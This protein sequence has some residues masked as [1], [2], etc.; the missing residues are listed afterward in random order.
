MAL[1]NFLEHCPV[2]HMVFVSSGAVYDGLVGDVTP[3]RPR[4]TRG[5]PTRSRSSHRSSTSRFFAERRHAVDS[6]ANVRFFGAYG[7]YEP[8]R[9]ITTRWMRAVMAGQRTFTVRGNG[10]NLIDFMYVD[11]AVDA[12]LRAGDRRRTSAA[13]STS[14]PQRR[15]ASTTSSQTMARVLGVEIEVRHE[16]DVPE[17]IEFPSPTPR[18]ANGSASTKVSFEDGIRRLHEF[19]RHQTA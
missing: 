3:V 18:C 14:R 17:Y 2:G 8:E 13:P 6:Y 9:K 19:F 11:D 12:F 5:C 4:S 16:G 10:Q 7:P 15:S 1:I